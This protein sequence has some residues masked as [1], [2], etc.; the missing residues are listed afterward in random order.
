MLGKDKK[1]STEPRQANQNLP[2][3]LQEDY[4]QRLHKFMF[5]SASGM[6]ELKSEDEH[7]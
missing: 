2:H 4:R 7:C 6:P 5:P 3:D 1:E